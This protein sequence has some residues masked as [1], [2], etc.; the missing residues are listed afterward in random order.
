MIPRKIKALY[1]SFLSP[2]MRVNAARHRIFSCRG[3]SLLRV[4]L[5]PGQNNYLK[6]WVNV[7]ANIITAKCDM[8]A[9]MR[10][11]LPFRDRSVDAVYSHHMI[12]HLPNPSEHFR[13]M[14]RVLKSGGVFR[15]GGPDAEQAFKRYIAMDHEWFGDFP[16]CRNSIGGRLDNFL[17][18]RQE[19]VALLT[20]SYLEEMALNAGLTDLCWGGPKTQTRFPALFDAAMLETEWETTPEYPHTIILEGVRP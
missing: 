10:Y 15:V 20:P 17:L 4:H 8:W 2:A 16:D 9:D 12:E 5:G 1:Y 11:K 19:H 6:G 14:F 18:C 13:E 3:D 7:D